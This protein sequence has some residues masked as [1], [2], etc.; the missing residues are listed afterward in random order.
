MPTSSILPRSSPRRLL[1]LLMA[2]AAASV[3]L[4]E[5]V[6]LKNEWI[7]A[8]LPGQGEV[9]VSGLRPLVRD[10]NNL[11]A[12]ASGEAFLPFD[13]GSDKEEGIR[14]AV[15]R[16]GEKEYV[17]WK[18]AQQEAGAVTLQNE[19]LG[20]T[21]ALRLP[22]GSS[23]MRV[24]LTFSKKGAVESAALEMMLEVGGTF[25]GVP[26]EGPADFLFAPVHG[27]DGGESFFHSP[28]SIESA[29]SLRLAAGWWA[30][31]DQVAHTALLCQ[32]D[33]PDALLVQEPVMLDGQEALRESLQL[34]LSSGTEELVVTIHLFDQIAELAAF[35]GRGGFALHKDERKEGEGFTLRFAVSETIPNGRLRLRV[36]G[37]NEPR[38]ELK[39][40]QWEPGKPYSAAI[41]AGRGPLEIEFSGDGFNEKAMLIIP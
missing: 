34:P 35:T 4:A 11:R 8:R 40:A 30:V 37:E 1:G 24:G 13:T 27:E 38:F 7:E 22:A 3:A 14:L 17:Y 26:T 28:I 36:P 19:E 18:V 25:L 10:F 33:F 39:A 29:A 2:A 23:Q 16:G 41:G 6:S 5:E 9:L 20:I 31:G 15:M 32:A 21:A 12:A